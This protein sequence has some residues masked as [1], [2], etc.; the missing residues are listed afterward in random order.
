MLSIISRSGWGAR[1]PAAPIPS[2][3]VSELYLHHSVGAGQVDKD[4]DGDRGDD[5][6]RAMQA[7]HMDVRGWDDIA[8]NH[9]HDPDGREFYV[10]RGFEKRPGAQRNHN[11]G[12][13]ALV[14]M[15][16]FTKRAVTPQLI[17]DIAS[18]YHQAQVAGL[19]PR[20]PVRGHRDAPD[21][22]TTCPGSHLYAALPAINKTINALHEED[23]M[24]L[25]EDDII[26][27]RN[28]VLSAFIGNSGLTLAQMI[29]NTHSYARQDLMNGDGLKELGS[30]ELTA[31]ARAVADEQHRRQAE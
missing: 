1:P 9:A 16:D 27:V 11:T 23:D 6:M 24:P 12:T 25:S 7:H 18:F 13:H 4:G 28:A 21:Q 2:T 31:I 19:L 30:A 15:G 29:Q 10:G 26:K 17:A 20:V 14:V 8:Y 5:Y 22:G 3:T